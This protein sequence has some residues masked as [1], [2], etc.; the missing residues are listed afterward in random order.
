MGKLRSFFHLYALFLMHRNGFTA[1]KWL[2]KENFSDLQPALYHYSVGC[3]CKWAMLHF[4]PCC[5]HPELPAHNAKPRSNCQTRQRR[6]N[7]NQ[8]FGTALVISHLKC[9]R[10]HILVYCSAEKCL[11]ARHSLKPGQNQ[12]A[13]SSQ[14]LTQQSIAV[15]SGCCS[16][17]FQDISVFLLHRRPSSMKTPL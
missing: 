14:Y 8:A 2:L 17:N 5:L 6:W 4:P 13:P 7:T 1:W 3:K 12:T 9:F 16:T 10:K 11:S 15:H